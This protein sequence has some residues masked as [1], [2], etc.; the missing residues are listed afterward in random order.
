ML[1]PPGDRVLPPAVGP[2]RPGRGAGARGPRGLLRQRARLRRGRL[3]PR[4]RQPPRGHGHL[5]RVQPPRERPRPDRDRPARGGRAHDGGQRDDVPDRRQGG[6]RRPGHLRHVHAQA[7]LPPPGLRH[8]HSLLPLRGRRERVLRPCGRVPALRHGPPVH[9]GPAAPLRGDHRGD[10]PVRQLL[11]APLGRGR[12]PVVHLVGAQ[13]PFR[14]RA[15][16]PVQAGQGRLG[17]HRVPRYRRLGQPVPRLRPADRGRAQGHRGGLRAA[18]GRRRGHQRA[19]HPR[20]ARARPRP[21]ARH[22]AR[23]PARRRG[24]RVRGIRSGRARLRRPAAQQAP[25]VGRLPGGGHAVRA[26]A[27]PLR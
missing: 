12:G 27:L 18:R 10:P 17:P 6:R 13:Q 25:G 20:A 3:P 14:P 21:P 11:Q 15:R 2:A 26:A 9:R 8:A 23:R 1:H 16:S 22:P 7:V 19:D 24:V 4:R 5:R